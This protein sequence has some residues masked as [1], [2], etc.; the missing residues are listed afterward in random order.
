MLP[1]LS[2]S[3]S[4]SLVL[5]EKKLKQG[6]NQS[7]LGDADGV[8]ITP[9]LLKYQSI[10][11]HVQLLYGFVSLQS[12]VGF[13]FQK[14]KRWHCPANQISNFSHTKLLSPITVFRVF[15]PFKQNSRVSWMKH[16]L[17]FSSPWSVRV[18]C[19]MQVTKWTQ[20]LGS[21]ITKQKTSQLFPLG[22][23][24]VLRC[25]N[26][27]CCLTVA[28]YE[29]SFTNSQT[30]FIQGGFSIYIA[31][32]WWQWPD[33]PKTLPTLLKAISLQRC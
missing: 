13:Y 28:T 32:W 8:D 1:F 24:L 27:P 21:C 26:V 19:S 29:L 31:V 15:P 6:E 10:G 3:D 4:I 7:M 11:L 2:D 30:L 20:T 23:F 18:S 25:S 5:Y 22:T 14:Y 16:P 17:H 33:R 9:V 12:S